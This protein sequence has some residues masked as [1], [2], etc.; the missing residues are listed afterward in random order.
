MPNEL[1]V[2]GAV[3]SKD[4][5]ALSRL[6][7][8][9]SILRLQALMLEDPDKLNLSTDCPVQH[10]F[11]PGMYGREITIPEG[12][13]I[14]GKLHRHSHLNCISKGRIAVFTEFG[15][16]VLEAPLTFVSEPGT[17]RVVLALTD[18]VW[19]TFHKTDSTDLA[20]IEREVIAED[21][22]DLGE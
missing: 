1:G 8:R 21:Y 16:E 3:Q 22:S 2:R 6:E 13:C 9:E 4:S 12:V 15:R 14:V 17:K 20:E 7:A 10:H 5:T 19:T 18:T 11:A